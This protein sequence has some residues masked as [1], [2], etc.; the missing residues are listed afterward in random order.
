MSEKTPERGGTGGDLDTDTPRQHRYPTRKRRAEAT[1]V[2]KSATPTNK[3]KGIEKEKS[4]TNAPRQTRRT[5]PSLR[6]SDNQPQ[7]GSSNLS[8][9]ALPPET[10]DGLESEDPEI[11]GDFTPPP[12][13]GA[14][15]SLR[16]ILRTAP[17]Q[18]RPVYDAKALQGTRA[19][20][21]LEVQQDER[22][23]K[24]VVAKTLVQQLL[25]AADKLIDGLGIDPTNVDEH[26][27][28]TSV[29]PSYTSR[30]LPLVIRTE[31]DVEDWA[32]PVLIRS[33][34]A[35]IKAITRSKSASA[36]QPD[37]SSPFQH[38]TEGKYPNITSAG[39]KRSIPDGIVLVKEDGA[40]VTV[41]IKSPPVMNSQ[42]ATSKYPPPFSQPL[43]SW[44]N[45]PIGRAMKFIWP[46]SLVDLNGLN[47][48]TKIIMQ[49]WSQMVAWK[50]KYAILTSYSTTIFFVK[51]GKDTLFMSHE[52][53]RM[54]RP[55][56]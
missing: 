32:I 34:L 42:N 22:L 16:V 38:V 49:V 20:T 2:A 7:A 19:P 23:Q 55:L 3:G 14:P 41:E 43:M 15:L 17:P 6:D 1:T 11:T 45:M 12:P 44:P 35:I 4:T 9:H 26:V 33:A 48:Q 40:K 56:H 53:S 8:T 50:V 36:T 18:C 28:L 10:H 51:K 54:E 52:V 31:H 13:A 29:H 24:I 30:D 25:P 5:C 47:K 21:L 46:G 27:W 37:S 39:G